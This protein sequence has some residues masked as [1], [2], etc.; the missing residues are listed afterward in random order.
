MARLRLSKLPI[1]LLFMLLSII[2]QESI[3]TNEDSTNV[4]RWLSIVYDSSFLQICVD[5]RL[6]STL[7]VVSSLV[8]RQLETEAI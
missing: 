7:Q 6:Q 4:I 2:Y 1:N 8:S 3:N 5:P